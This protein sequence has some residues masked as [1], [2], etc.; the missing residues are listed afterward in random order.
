MSKNVDIAAGWVAVFMLATN[1]ISSIYLCLGPSFYMYIYFEE[2]EAKVFWIEF[3]SFTAGY[4]IPLM[5]ILSLSWIV[6]G[7]N[8]DKKWV[9]IVQGIATVVAVIL[10]LRSIVTSLA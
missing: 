4:M 1:L 5:A 6:F 3:I 9:S 8:R 10:F 2:F 7:R